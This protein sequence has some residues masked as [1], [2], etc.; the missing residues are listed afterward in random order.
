L[1]FLN[2]IFSISDVYIFS[3]ASRVG[4]DSCAVDTPKRRKC[5]LTMAAGTCQ[6]A[7]GDNNP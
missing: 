3:A 4:R 5:P 1:T 2:R 6:F 7:W